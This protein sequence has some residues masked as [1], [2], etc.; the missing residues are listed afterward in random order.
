MISAPSPPGQRIIRFRDLRDLSD[1]RRFA[2]VAVWLLGWPIRVA[3]R[4]GQL[5]LVIFQLRY[6]CKAQVWVTNTG[7]GV[8]LKRSRHGA[9]G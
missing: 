5:G 7:I 4:E 3:Y 9:G 6:Y 1:L 2:S 8:K